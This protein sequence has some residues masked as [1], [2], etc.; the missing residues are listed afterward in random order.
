MPIYW[1]IVQKNMQMLDILKTAFIIAQ[2][3]ASYRKSRLIQTIDSLFFHN[4]N[5][6]ARALFFFKQI[7]K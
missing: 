6:K 3:Y 5:K 4:T 7:Y 2:N 1:K